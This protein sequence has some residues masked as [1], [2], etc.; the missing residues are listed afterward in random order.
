MLDLFSPCLVPVKA[1]RSGAR[2]GKIRDAQ[3]GNGGCNKL[4]EQ[5]E[6]HLD[7]AHP[8]S[9]DSLIVLT[10]MNNI[11]TTTADRVRIHFKRQLIT[12]VQVRN[13]S[14]A[15]RISKRRVVE[16]SPDYRATG[17][18]SGTQVMRPEVR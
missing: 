8:A 18:F 1:G 16:Q 7:S 2:E 13:E 3:H 9:P 12:K 11:T 6:K 17:V 14:M 10:R 5:D 15:T 4:V